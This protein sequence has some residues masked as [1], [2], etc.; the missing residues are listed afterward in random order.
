VLVAGLSILALTIVYRRRLWAHLQSGAPPGILPMVTLTLIFVAAS[1]RAVP[2]GDEPH[3]LIITQSVLRDGD[4]DL[5]NNYQHQDY[6]E[7]YP[8]SIPDPHIIE[9]GAHW[10]PVHAIGLPLIA[11]PFFA[12]AGRPGVVVLLSILTVAGLRVLWSVLRLAGFRAP[13]AGLTTMVA[14]LT[15]PVAVMAGQVFP[16]VPAFFLVVVAL[17]ACL[18]PRWSRWDAFRMLL[19]LGLLPWLHPKYLVLSGALLL[20]LMLTRGRALGTATYV[21]AAAV[22][23]VSVIGHAVLS[24]RW[25]GAA[26][27]GAGILVTRGTSPRDW[28]PSIVGHFLV[29]PWVGLLGV[30]LD[31]QSG[32]LLASPVYLLSIPGLVLLWRRARALA[33]AAGMV[34][35]S[36][37]LLAGS[38]GVWYGGYCSPARLLTPSVPVLAL[39][40]ASVLEEG[41]AV[42]RKLFLALASISVVHAALMMT[43]PSF[44]RYGDPA[45]NHNFFLSRVERVL[46]SDLTLLFPS[47]RHMEP[48][49]WLTT[50]V[51]VV[52]VAGLTLAVL[53]RQPTSLAGLTAGLRRT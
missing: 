49:T 12:A 18:V 37:Y 10:Y 7:Y 6:R 39:G 15:L 14:A 13:V 30:L 44:T 11:A 1:L 47:F 29:T 51:Y 27:P 35:A 22:V 48:I 20:C 23:L 33:L 19:S 36:I 9:R 34:F 4:F 2:T 43:L 42:I 50:A 41:D 3:Y 28:V 16:E 32:L 21:G 17:H 24:Y 5:R 38:F 31:Q 26:L 53:R 8:D 25:Y 40:L 45:T 46:G 52:G